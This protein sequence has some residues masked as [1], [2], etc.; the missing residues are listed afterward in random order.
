MAY[1]TPILDCFG[2]CYPGVL[3]VSRLVWMFR[4]TVCA[5]EGAA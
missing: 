1:V 2:K 3:T 4:W 5:T